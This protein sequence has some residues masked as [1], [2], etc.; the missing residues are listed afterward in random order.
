MHLPQGTFRPFFVSFI[1]V[2][3]LFLWPVTSVSAK[4]A[5]ASPHLDPQAGL[6]CK[7]CNLRFGKVKVGQNK[8]L[9]VT[10]TNTQSSTVTI[11]QMNQNAPGFGVSNLSLPLTLAPGQ[12]VNFNVTF[13]PT[14]NGRVSG[15][16]QFISDA[17]NGT[18]T[19]YLYGVG[20]MDGSL[21]AT[22]WGLDFGNV[23]VGSSKSQP[24]T[25]TNSGASSV[26]ISQAAITG[27]GF[28]TSGLNP[29]VTLTPGQKFSFTVTFA[30]NVGGN[31]IGTLS[32]LSDAP[33]P[34]LTIPLSGSGTAAALLTVTPATLSFGDVTVGTS[35]SLQ[36]TLSASGANATVSSGTI[37]SSEFV[38]SGLTF[39]FTVAAGQNASYTA[40][41]TPQ[42][43]GTAS[44]NATF[45][46]DAS[47]SPT[48]ESLTGNGTPPPQHSV[49]L[50]W[51]SSQ[52]PDV[53]G[54]NVY[55]GGKSGGPYTKVNPALDPSVTYT[56][57]TVQGGQNYYYVTTAVDSGG[58][59]STYSNEV[60]AAIPFP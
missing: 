58:T 55:R 41:F 5:G 49:D 57:A 3:L 10:L 45:V 4:K 1:I 31:A 50:S 20:F 40:T 48:V 11:S 37:N 28:S 2:A 16:I 9:P 35:K 47:N 34:A 46:S 12:S 23:Q 39:P 51:D 17:L 43:S 29:P 8:T 18:L 60:K 30:P 59:E 54:Y 38:L 7:P 53:V 14:D 44:A 56:D 42:N 19:I 25:L 27:A 52:T 22:P 21:T 15:N 13:T 24:E 6:V 36:G 33:N 26:T 32:A